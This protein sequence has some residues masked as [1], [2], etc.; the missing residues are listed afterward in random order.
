[1]TSTPV[2]ARSMPEMAGNSISTMLSRVHVAGMIEDNGLIRWSP[3]AE[4]D[5][6]DIWDY[7]WSAASAAVADKRLREIHHVC[8]LLGRSSELGKA[9]DDVRAGLRSIPVDRHVVFYRITKEAIEIVRVLDERRDVEA[10]FWDG[11]P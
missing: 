2:S 8:W 11:E 3:E 7:I 1:M 4:Q 6:F 10:I 5:L 9:R